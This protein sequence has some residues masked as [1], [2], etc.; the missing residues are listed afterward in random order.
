MQRDTLV[1]DLIEKEL[2]RQ[3]QG[4]EPAGD[5]GHGHFPYQ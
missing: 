5:A 4:I 1:F 2:D 3:R